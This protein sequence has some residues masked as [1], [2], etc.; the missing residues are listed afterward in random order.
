MS[1]SISVDSD[2]VVLLLVA[3]AAAAV[4]FNADFF[5]NFFL[6]GSSFH[7]DASIPLD[8]SYVYQDTFITT[9]TKTIKMRQ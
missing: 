8:A 3:A 7:P 5:L 9:T 2:K 4:L 1:M 6:F